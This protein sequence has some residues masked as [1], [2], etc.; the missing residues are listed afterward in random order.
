VLNIRVVGEPE[1]A[2]AEPMLLAAGLVFTHAWK[3]IMG[4]KRVRA[5]RPD[6]EGG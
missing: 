3:D 6:K 2:Q 1:V 5:R 4:V